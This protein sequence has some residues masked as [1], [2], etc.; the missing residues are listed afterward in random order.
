MINI[1]NKIKNTVLTIA[2]HPYKNNV[3]LVSPGLNV[4]AD[5]HI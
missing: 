1:M 5:A 2:L 4:H 3:T